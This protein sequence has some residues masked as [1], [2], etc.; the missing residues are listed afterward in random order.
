MDEIT[1]IRPTTTGN[2]VMWEIKLEDPKFGSFQDSSFAGDMPDSLI[3]IG[4]FIVRV[5]ITHVCSEFRGCARLKPQFLTAVQGLKLLPL[6]QFSLLDGLQLF[7]L[8]N[9]C[10]EHYRVSQPRETLSVTNAKDSFRLVHIL[11][12]VYLNPLTTFRRTF[13]A[14]LIQPNSSFSKTDAAVIQTINNGRSPNLWHVTRTQ[15]VDLDGL[16]ERMNLDHSTIKKNLQTNDQLAD[17]LTKGKFTTM[18]WHAL[19][20][21]WQLR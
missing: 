5:W 13:R 12:I 4:R 21:L 2:A 18:Q 9:V 6:T 17:I 14:A 1:S 3:K 15:R 16:F 20:T 11:T 10:C 7:N 8:E 19:L